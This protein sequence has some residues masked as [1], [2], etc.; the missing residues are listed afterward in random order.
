MYHRLATIT[1]TVVQWY[2][3][4]VPHLVFC[5][6]CEIHVIN[7]I[8]KGGILLFYNELKFKKF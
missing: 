3:V 8:Y 7:M 5:V 6:F 1:Q 2:I 4:P